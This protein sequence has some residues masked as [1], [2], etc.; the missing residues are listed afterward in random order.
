M[1]VEAHVLPLDPS[2]V[3]LP[4]PLLFCLIGYAYV[5]ICFV[6]L[7]L[8]SRKQTNVAGNDFAQTRVC[9]RA[10]MCVCMCVRV[11]VQLHGHDRVGILANKALKF[12]LCD[13]LVLQ[14]LSQAHLSRQLCP[15]LL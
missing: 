12:L 6:V 11:C 8:L 15:F 2:Q 1:D 4:P 7:L 3:L 10:R 14:L 5:W 9:A 13:L